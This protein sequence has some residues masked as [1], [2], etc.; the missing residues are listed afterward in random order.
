M[1][2][3]YW[4]NPPST[5]GPHLMRSPLNR[6]TICV[7]N[8]SQMR[9]KA[10]N[11]VNVFSA[12]ETQLSGIAPPAKLRFICVEEIYAFGAHMVRLFNGERIKCVSTVYA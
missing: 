6:R 5:G 11:C 1:R 8:A 9:I 3:S 10:V 12:Y 4:S 2:T 7:S